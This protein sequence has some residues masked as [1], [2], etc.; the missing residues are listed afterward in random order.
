MT[1]AVHDHDD[2]SHF[3]FP[4]AAVVSQAQIPESAVSLAHTQQRTL[5]SAKD[6]ASDTNS[7]FPCCRLCEVGPVL[8]GAVR[9]GWLALPAHGVHSAE[10]CLFE[11]DAPAIIVNVSHGASDY[12]ALR[13]RDFT[14]TRTT[15]GS[16][17]RGAAS[18]S[19]FSN[20]N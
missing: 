5:T 13:A 12:M 15:A 2:D 11:A 14:P 3:V 19:T 8:S 17:L 9:P 1:R 18:F 6:R 4:L 16:Q 10:Q 20:M 7:R